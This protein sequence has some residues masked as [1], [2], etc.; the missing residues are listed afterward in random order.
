MG[1]ASIQAVQ[2]PHASQ[3]GALRIRGGRRQLDV[4]NQDSEHHPRPVPARDRK[5]VLAV[6]R[7]PRAGSGLSID[8]VVGVDVHHEPRAGP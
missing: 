6:D 1:H 8:V 5:R 3:A 7:D 4:G 2:E